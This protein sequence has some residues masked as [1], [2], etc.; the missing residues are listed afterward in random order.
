MLKYINMS[1]TPNTGTISSNKEILRKLFINAFF[2]M[3]FLEAMNSVAS[4]I[5]SYFMGN[6]IGSYGMAAMG[7]ARPF[8]SFVDILCGPLGLGMQL[9]CSHYIGKADVDHAQKVFSG[10]FTIGTL[11]SIVLMILGMS[12]SKYIVQMYGKGVEVAEV[13]PLAE[14]Y[15]RALFIGAP[16]MVIFGILYPVVQLGNGK[17][18]I[19]ISVFMQAVADVVGD[20]LSVF[21]FHGGTFGMGLATAISYY[22]AL[23]PLFAYFLKKEPILSL[24]FSLL[25]IPDLKDI[26]DS[27]LSKSIKRVCNTIK[28]ILMNGLSLL[29][30]TSLAVS[31]YSIT[32]QLRDFLISFSAGVS[33]AVVL[34]GALLYSQR[35]RDGLDY[36]SKLAI[37]SNIIIAMLG[38]LCFVFARPI[39]NI[40]ISDSEELINMVVTS[41]RCIGIMIPFSTFNGV[42]ISYMQVTKQYGVVNFLSYMNRLVLIVIVSALLG[43]VFGI[44]GLWWA[45]PV[46]EIINVIISLVVVVGKNGKLPRKSIDMLCLPQ[47]FGYSPE[48]YIE[49][50]VKNGE[51][52]TSLLDTVKE[53]CL[54]HN[55]DSKR[56][57]Y[58]QI[59]LEELAMNVIEHGFEKCKLANPVIHVW[60]TYEDGNL[61]LRFQDNCPGFN[62]MKHCSELK[63][64]NPESCVGL[65]LISGISKDMKYVNALNTNN[66]VISI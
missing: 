5:D 23:I 57:L 62:V 50:S 7:F 40:F 16:A 59:A 24:R 66:L 49:V 56:T 22:I 44:N 12:L 41:I 3:F 33:G 19:S 10:S 46:S 28:P 52:V 25:S 60:I 27:G 65:R 8:Y 61:F 29:L 55:I 35:D 18:I 17:K 13:L 53:F 14:S 34:I 37:R 26:F 42:F 15:L 45:F 11:I 63:K 38:A 51:E 6:Y 48:D 32:T 31:A 54:N 2:A 64:G 58:S 1:T 20:A 43:F 9:V 30:G 47:D 39:A 36:V 4:L 21:V